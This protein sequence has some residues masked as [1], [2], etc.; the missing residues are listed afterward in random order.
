MVVEVEMMRLR[1]LAKDNA[2]CKM[3]K[4][5]EFLADALQELL[6]WRTSG[7]KKPE[8][9][10]VHCPYCGLTFRITP[11]NDE[12][13]I[14]KMC[15]GIFTCHSFID[16]SQICGSDE[17]ED[18]DDAVTRACARLWAERNVGD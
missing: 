12:E 11:K 15:G 17:N 5:Y 7:L 10:D 4:E 16:S 8:R 9:C 6:D 2:G 14:C 13:I 1:E 3:G 18:G